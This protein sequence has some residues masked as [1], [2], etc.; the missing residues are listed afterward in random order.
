MKV[1]CKWLILVLLLVPGEYG[2]SND[3]NDHN[4]VGAWG[5]LYGSDELEWRTEYIFNKDGTGVYPSQPSEVFYIE[6]ERFEIPETIEEKFHWETRVDGELKQLRLR[7][8]DD[9]WSSWSDYRIE[10]DDE[11]IWGPMIYSRIRQ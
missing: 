11:L 5:N 4:L 6:G 3:S 8:G 7:W 1:L 9:E 10:F 2:G